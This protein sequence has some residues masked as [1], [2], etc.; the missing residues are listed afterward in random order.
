MLELGRQ[1]RLYAGLHTAYGDTPTPAS[2]DALRHVMFLTTHDPTNRRNSPEKQFSPFHFTR[3]NGRETASLL[4][5]TALLR[6]SGALNTLPEASEVLEAAFGAKTNVTLSTTISAGTGAVGG[7]TLTS[8][9]G[10]AKHDAILITCPDGVKRVRRLTAVNTGT[11]VVAWAPNLAQAPADGAAVKA[12]IAYKP[13]TGLALALWFAHY[14]TKTDGSTAGFSRALYGVGIDRLSLAIDGAQ[15]ETQFTVSGPGQTQLT[16]GSVPSKPAAFTSVGGNPPPGYQTE[17]WIANATHPFLK[18]SIEMANALK[19]RNDEAGEGTSNRATELYRVGRPEISVALD[20]RVEDE[21][22]IY[23]PS[24]AGTN[25]GVFLQQGFTEGNIWALAMPQVEFKVPDT[26]DEDE[27]LNW[28]FKGMA[29]ASADEQND[30]I[31]LY[32]F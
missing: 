21:S 3:F 16:G 30:P 28:P 32:M 20:C 25:L 22:V 15:D 29:L 27:E 31:F 13:T 12:G 4:Q 11:G 5:L 6:P 1:G 23:D 2:T 14:G 18:A 8:A 9:T 7:A 19:V 26:G 24:E 10:L 17:L